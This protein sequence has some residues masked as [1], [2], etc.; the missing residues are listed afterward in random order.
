MSDPRRARLLEVVRAKGHLHL[1]EPV[2][3]A[4]GQLSQ[5]FIDCKA[6]LECWEDLRLASELIADSLA[7]AGIDFDAVGGPTLGADALSVGV[8]AV[9]DKKWFIVRKEAKS[10]G[11]ARLIEGARIEAGMRLLVVDDVITT[12]GS[13]LKAID[14]VEETGGVVCAASTVVDRGDTATERFAARGVW[15]RPLLSYRDLGIEPLG[16]PADPVNGPVTT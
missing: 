11:T 16:Q 3:L 7:A 6:A 15:Y 5:D 4:S 13:L 8:A 12:G 14:A 1:D 2:E 10:R 9:T